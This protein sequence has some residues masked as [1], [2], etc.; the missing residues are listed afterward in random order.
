[1]SEIVKTGRKN[2]FLK[3]DKIGN[4]S[5]FRVLNNLKTLN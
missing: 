5:Q 3:R 1:M 4:L 2:I